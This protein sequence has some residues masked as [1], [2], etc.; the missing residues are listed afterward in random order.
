M[1]Y[2]VRRELCS[3]EDSRELHDGPVPNLTNYSVA[4]VTDPQLQPQPSVTASQKAIWPDW[5][6]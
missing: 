4:Q 2:N 3:L 5:N 1:L 6:V